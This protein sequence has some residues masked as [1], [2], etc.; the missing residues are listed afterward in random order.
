MS[1]KSKQIP[2]R[3]P[4]I[5]EWFESRADGSADSQLLH[6]AE[7]R[8]QHHRARSRGCPAGARFGGDQA[9]S[10]EYPDDLRGPATGFSLSAATRFAR[11]RPG[12]AHSRPGHL[13]RLLPGRVPKAVGQPRS[14]ARHP[15]P[16]S[17]HVRDP[18]D[19]VEG[20]A[21]LRRPDHV[22]R[23]QERHA[24]IFRARRVPLSSLQ[25]SVRLLSYV[26]KNNLGCKFYEENAEII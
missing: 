9:L 15:H 4:A 5:G 8:S 3:L 11:P 1:Q 22:F 10:G 18:N 16:A 26:I 13:R 12:Q 19:G 24:A 6:V 7:R 17:A 20:R 14:T 25:E 23:A 21:H 2:R